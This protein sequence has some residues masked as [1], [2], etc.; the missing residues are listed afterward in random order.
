[1]IH[2]DFRMAKKTSAKKRIVLL[3]SHAIIHRAYHALPEFTGP[4]GAPTGALYGLVAMLLKIITDLKPDY[5]AACFDLPKPTIRHEAYEH[6]KATRV[7]TEDALALQLNESRKV[8]DAFSIPLYEREGFEADDLLGTIAHE[9]REEGVDVIIASGDMDALQLVDDKRVRVYTLKKG[10][11]DTILYDEKAVIERYGFKPE[12]I[13]DWKGLRGDPS[14]NIKGVPGIGEKTATE[15]VKGFGTIEK[16]YMALSKGEAA[17]LKKGV[18]ARMIGLLKEHEEDAR[19]SKSLATIRTDAPIAFTLPERPWRETAEL[20]KVLAMCEEFGFRSL[21]ERAKKVLANGESEDGV[22]RVAY[23]VPVPEEVEPTALTE[24]QVMLWLISSEFTNP[25]LDDILAFTK[26]RTFAAARAELEKQLSASGKVRDVYEHIEKPLIPVVRRMEE[27]G[28]RIDPKVLG[29]LAQTYRTELTQIEKRIYKAAGREFNVSSP[30][31]LGEVLFDELKIVPEKQKKTAGG[32]RSTRESE[33]EKI[34]DEHPIVADIL[35]YRELK[36]LLSTYIENLP[37]LLD[38]SH[39]L[40][41]QFL[42]TGTTTGRM[43]SQ[44]PNLQNIPLHSE[45]GRAIRHAFVASKGFQLVALDYSQIELRLAAILSGD[46]KLCDIFK[47]G[48][49][50]HQEVAA[51]VFHV[52]PE[53]VDSEMRRRAKVVNFGILY[54]MGVNALRA[55]LGSTTAEAHQYLDEY[56]A[57]FKT[58]SEYL[59]RTKGF[60]RK[61]GYTETLF[62]RRR[63]FPEMKSSLPYVRAQ[64]ERMAVNAPIQGTQADIIKLAM[65][66]IDEMLRKEGA[67]EDAYLLLQVHDELVYEIRSERAA[68][69]GANIKSIMES[70]LSAEETRGVPIITVMKSGPDW[71]TMHSL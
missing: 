60:A 35:D 18:K 48:R 30:K 37:P 56:F 46:K 2:A 8:F 47:S 36:K 29:A 23:V 19:F 39:R 71:G 50:V 59:E 28:I 21:R 3:D 1:M 58:L 12:L 66:R 43:A 15:L 6:Y 61:H 44:S 4:S 63:Q 70:V 41:A 55:Q 5:L 10:I 51:Q 42:Q 7:K 68:M 11:N 40:H 62:G 27:R 57:T 54:G 16:M 64:A 13:P 67:L 52:P 17:F 34:R 26:E 22:E 49:D 25:S 53:K 38:A 20:Q 9:L 24:A 65:V 33:L 45:R 32:Q 31:Q 14:D 69:L